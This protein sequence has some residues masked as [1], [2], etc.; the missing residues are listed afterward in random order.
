MVDRPTIGAETDS[1]EL[2]I[3]QHHKAQDDRLNET[4]RALMEARDEQER[5][6]RA[7]AVQHWG[8]MA[9]LA[10]TLIGGS[11]SVAVWYTGRVEADV[12]SEER[13]KAQTER[14]D[15]LEDGLDDVES[16][17]RQLRRVHS[18]EQVRAARTETMLETLLE[19][20]GAPAPPKTR[21]EEK[22]EE[23]IQEIL[24]SGQ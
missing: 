23:E 11:I 24:D 20:Q 15:A 9:A 22:A 19:V 3:S 17:V 12:R 7:K 8:A 13:R 18:L 1:L 10:A 6:S 4:V 14:V 5:E 2:L 16:E 21:A